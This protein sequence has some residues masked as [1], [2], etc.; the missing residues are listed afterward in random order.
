MKINPVA[1]LA[2][3]AGINGLVQIAGKES[4]AWLRLLAAIGVGVAV[5]SNLRDVIE[6]QEQAEVQKVEELAEDKIIMMQPIEQVKKD[7]AFVT[8]KLLN[9]Y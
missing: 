6:K 3:A 9:W 1:V 5:V 4:P 7:V 2:V 8:G